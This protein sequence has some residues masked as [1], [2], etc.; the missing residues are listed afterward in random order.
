MSSIARRRRSR[1]MRWNERRSNAGVCSPETSAMISG[2]R[3]NQ[4][5]LIGILVRQTRT[6]LDYF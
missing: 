3:S 1:K 6:E 2:C 5:G 4:Y